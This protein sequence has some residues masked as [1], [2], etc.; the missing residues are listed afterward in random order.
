MATEDEND[1]INL[2]DIREQLEADYQAHRKGTR[3]AEEVNR[4]LQRVIVPALLNLLTKVDQHD[5]ELEELVTNQ[6]GVQ[7]P[8]ELVDGLYKLFDAVDSDAGSSPE[9][10][11]HSAACRELMDEYLSDE[12]D[13]DDEDEDEGDEEEARPE[14][15]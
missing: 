14:A 8:A 13:D 5:E 3:G 1:D 4:R 12:D 6:G 10:K 15:Q 9:A 11:A 7:L 2:D